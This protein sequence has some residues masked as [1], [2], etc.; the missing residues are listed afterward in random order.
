MYPKLVSGADP[1]SAMQHRARPWLSL[2]WRG[3][4]APPRS[5]CHQQA[6]WPQVHTA[7][8][9]RESTSA[10][11]LRIS[12]C[13]TRCAGEWCRKLRQLDVCG[14]VLFHMATFYP[15]YQMLMRGKVA[16]TSQAL[17]YVTLTCVLFLLVVCT[18]V[19]V[20]FA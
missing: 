2:R 10:M 9:S 1:P 8:Q 17:V 16:C 7:R 18:C 13:Q 14:H 12:C 11:K 6:Y 3:L 5:M 20:M 15:P 19:C 4:E